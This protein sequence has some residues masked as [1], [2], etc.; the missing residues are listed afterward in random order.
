M[1]QA[2]LLMWLLPRWQIQELLSPAPCQQ[3][4]VAWP[5]PDSTQQ[6]VM[7]RSGHLVAPLQA[8]WD[9]VVRCPLVASQ[10]VTALL[11]ELRLPAPRP[12]K[13]LMPPLQLRSQ[14]PVS[15]ARRVLPA[16]ASAILGL[17]M[18]P[19][20]VLV[21]VAMGR[22]Q[23]LGC[24]VLTAQ[25]LAALQLP[26]KQLRAAALVLALKSAKVDQPKPQLQLQPQL[27]RAI[28]TRPGCLR[29]KQLLPQQLLS[30]QL[31]R[32]RVQLHQQ[33]QPRLLAHCR[34]AGAPRKKLEY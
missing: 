26:S 4:A 17:W 5:R 19:R 15:V 9:A 33:R 2:L 12:M 24:P 32:P 25:P 30:L 8:L 14:L 1:P 10:Q 23:R 34:R 28:L 21:P 20:L 3:T 29:Q 13:Y 31:R 18:P 22:V 16:R 6:A 7:G 11:L 27:Q